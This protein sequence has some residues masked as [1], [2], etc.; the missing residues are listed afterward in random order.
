MTNF[1]GAVLILFFAKQAY[2]HQ[3]SHPHAEDKKKEAESLLVTGSVQLK[4]KTQLGEKAIQ[5]TGQSLLTD[6]LSNQVG[7][8]S[9]TFCSNCGAKRLSINGFKAE[10]TT[11]MID[12]VPLVSS[13]SS[14]YG[15]DALPLSQ[16]NQLVIKRGSGEALSGYESMAGSVN[17]VT[18][19]PFE[20]TSKLKMQ[21]NMKDGLSTSLEQYSAM[22]SFD[23]IEK[24]W[25]MS[26]GGEW[27]GNSYWDTDKNGISEFPQKNNYSAFLKSSYRINSKNDLNIRLSKSNLEFLGGNTVGYKASSIRPAPATQTDFLNGDVNNAFLGSVDKISDFVKIDRLE[28][29]YD[30]HLNSDSHFKLNLKGGYAQQKQSSIYQHGFDYTNVDDLMVSDLNFEFISFEDHIFTVGL[31]GRYEDF[32][33]ESYELFSASRLGLSRD[34]FTQGSVAIYAEDTWSILENLELHS[35]L[36][37][38]K[39]QIQWWALDKKINDFVVAPRFILENSIS[40]HLSQQASYGLGYRVPQTFFE[41]QHGANERGFKLNLDQFEKSHSGV[42]SISYNEPSYYL[43]IGTQVTLLQNM[44][45]SEEVP[46]GPL[47]YTNDPDS[48]HIYVNEIL[49]GVKVIPEWFLELSFEFFN[50]DSGYKKKLPTAA[51]EKRVQLKSNLD[52]GKFKHSLVAMFI[53]ERNIAA[54]AEYEGHHNVL[55]FDGVNFS[56]LNPKNQI[57]PSFFTLDTFVSYQ[58]FSNT[59]F[60]FGIN[61][62]FNFTQTSAKDSPLSWHL[63]VNEPHLDSLHNW[64]PNRGREF[65]FRANIQF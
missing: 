2:S 9:Q 39:S 60:T 19:D 38:E 50:Y 4:S 63:D 31:F 33:A 3:T 23:L 21:L 64:G 11:I 14:F 5:Q 62:L 52:L 12:G 17:V 59:I 43:T 42:Y 15:L 28:G 35:A 27:G 20:S 13:I 25:A 51:I 65:Y 34:N 16:V 18:I 22:S 37:L 58:A 29:Q 30:W 36:R 49:T 54:Y 1:L 6:V 61:N 48:H 10:Q 41:S 47:T 40:E 26:L 8:Q 44:T 32:K 56:V 46:N 57:A 7:I 45:Y 55:Q 24:K 53:P